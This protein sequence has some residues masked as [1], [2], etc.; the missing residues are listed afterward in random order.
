MNVSIS[1]RIKALLAYLFLALGGALVLLFS[2]KDQFAVFHARQSL[3]LTA[4][5][6]LMVL[7]WLLVAY[8][9]S[10]I[11][12]AGPVLA[13]STFGLVIAAF[14]LLI[15]GWIMGM[16]HA[17]RAE[18]QRVPLIGNLVKRWR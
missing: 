5:A 16:I 3:I 1:S 2:R 13:S 8:P 11:P 9:L 18:E 17:L 10:W 4:A 7:L 15:V 6:I 12:F 14:A